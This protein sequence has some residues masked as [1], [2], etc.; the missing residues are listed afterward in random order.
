MVY[1]KV[2]SQL[3]NF[4]FQLIKY[5]NFDILFLIKIY[6]LSARVINNFLTFIQIWK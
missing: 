4:I 5:F 1:T 6:S 2:L 3:I